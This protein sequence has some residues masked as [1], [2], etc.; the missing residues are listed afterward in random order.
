M[1]LLA[2]RRATLDLRRWH[3]MTTLHVCA[4]WEP[5]YGRSGSMMER[6]SL[7]AWNFVAKDGPVAS[8]LIEA[9]RALVLHDRP[10]MVDL[11]TLTLNHGVFH[12]RA[13][14]GFAEARAIMGDWRPNISV[15]D[16]DH[17]DSRVLLGLCLLYT[18]D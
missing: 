16:M 17:D 7:A 14:S 13:A 9:R 5:S 2:H 18:S 6:R 15:I 1:G 10:L 3:V 12:V 11:I 8:P 4:G